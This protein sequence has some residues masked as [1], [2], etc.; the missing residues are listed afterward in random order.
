MKKMSLLLICFLV[1]L[2]FYA[3]SVWAADVCVSSET[4]FHT[5]LSDA[6][7]SGDSDIIRVVQGTYNGNF[8]Y[9]SIESNSIILL[10]GCIT[11]CAD[12]IVDPANTVL[13]ASGSG[14][15]LNL[16]N[17]N[18]GDIIVE[19]FTIQGGSATGSYSG[20]VYAHS[21]SD[22]GTAGTVALTDN[23]VTGN[24]A[25]YY[26]GVYAR[27]SSS[28][29]SAGDVSLTHN[30]VT[31]NT[32]TNDYGGVYADSVISGTGTAG[33]VNLTNNTITGNTASNDFG[34]VFAESSAFSGTAGDV[35]LTN[36]TIAGTTATNN[37]GGVRAR[38]FGS[39]A[40]GIITLINNTI[41]GNTAGGYYGGVFTYSYSSSS[42]AGDITLT[43]NTVTGNTATN[44]CGGVC[45]YMDSNTI[46]F[47]N[48]ISWGN[49]AAMGSGDDIYLN[50]TGTTNG[51]NNDY[52]D[53]SGTW[54]GESGYNI[55]L[56]PLFVNPGAGDYHLSFASPCINMGTNSATGIPSNDFEGDPRIIGGTVDIGADEHLINA[57]SHILLLLLN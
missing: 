2:A 56:D 1:S 3:N 52:S 14:T 26:G 25:T 41:T 29:G 33:K 24:T 18:S 13:D 47:Y 31:G 39:T 35:S 42:T 22:S 27:S 49:T 55:N 20:G 54:S 40:S 36:N 53:L 32:A 46:N 34:G 7:D 37:Y 51:Y 30:T 38:S 15:V 57:I 16:R 48:N 23:M 50:G 17:S 10:G 44:D 21:Y 6:E 28:S 43:N 4:E 19:G 5:A 9:I 11:G 12:R 45:I 8:S